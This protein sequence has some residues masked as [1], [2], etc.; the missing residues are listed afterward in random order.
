M[1]DYRFTVEE[2]KKF[3]NLEN[4]SASYLIPLESPHDLLRCDEDGFNSLCCD[5]VVEDGYMLQ[6]WSVVFE[7]VDGK[8][9]LRVNVQDADEWI[10]THCE[11]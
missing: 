9:N 4:N 11:S 6:D 1:S 5:D 10:D 8:V 2:F 7:V 3:V